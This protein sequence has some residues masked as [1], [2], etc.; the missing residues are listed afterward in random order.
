LQSP[1]GAST[2]LLYVISGGGN[3]KIRGETDA[4]AAESLIHVPRGSGY[5]LK[6]AAPDKNEKML[7]VRFKAP[8]RPSPAAVPNHAPGK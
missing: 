7:V 3:I 6:A 8:A 4:L 1:G 2:E 5:V